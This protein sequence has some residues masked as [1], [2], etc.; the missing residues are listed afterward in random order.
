[1]IAKEIETAS[2]GG[3]IGFGWKITFI[4]VL[5]LMLSQVL[6]TLITVL[7]FEEVLLDTYITKYEI[8]GQ[9]LQRQIEQSLRFGKRL[10]GFVGMNALLRSLFAR[11]P[12]ITSVIISAP[13][14]TILYSLT[15][16]KQQGQH[17]DITD[18]QPLPTKRLPFSPENLLHA[19]QDRTPLTRHE[20]QYYIFFPIKAAFGQ[21]GGVLSILFEQSVLDQKKLA[22]VRNAWSKLCASLAITAVI[23]AMGI[24]LFFILPLRRRSKI[25]SDQF[26]YAARTSDRCTLPR[27]VTHDELQTTFYSMLAFR[28]K[29]QQ[30]EDEF[31]EKNTSSK[32]IL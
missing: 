14:G 28:S 27:E 17:A 32:E 16:G 21:E 8:L 20:K 5:L 6:G 11:S 23:I 3:R 1:M 10:N 29:C 22:L 24:Y 7:A 26:Q 25:F 2:R 18:L 13:D 31:I 9:D 4:S 30:T 12:D 15:K 19:P